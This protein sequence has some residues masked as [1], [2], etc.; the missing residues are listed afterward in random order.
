MA[1]SSGRGV[2]CSFLQV[3][4]VGWREQTSLSSHQEPRKSA[5][6]SSP[7]LNAL[8]LDITHC[9]QR[10]AGD[11]KGKEG[12]IRA[13]GLF[14]QAVLGKELLDLVHIHH[15]LQSWPP[16]LDPRCCHRP[17]SD[18][19]DLPRQPLVINARGACRGSNLHCFPVAQ[20]QPIVCIRQR[21]RGPRVSGLTAP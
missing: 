11:G 17:N 4:S 7:A 13:K 5:R 10:R 12:G 9:G 19:K 1:R 3:S 8:W 15:A 21:V 20:G 18:L 2:N 14:F 6:R 16:A